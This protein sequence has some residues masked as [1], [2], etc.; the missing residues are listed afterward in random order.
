M[1]RG[2]GLHRSNRPC[3]VESDRAA[4]LHICVGVENVDHDTT[5][6]HSRTFPLRLDHDLL[7]YYSNKLCRPVRMFPRFESRSSSSI[8]KRQTTW[9]FC[10]CSV[11]QLKATF[12]LARLYSETAVIF[13]K[14][15]EQNRYLARTTWISALSSTGSNRKNTWAQVKWNESV[16][17]PKREQ[18]IDGGSW[19]CAKERNKRRTMDMYIRANKTRWNTHTP[20]YRR[21]AQLESIYT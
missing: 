12:A 5:K 7:P 16:W 10:R 20:M 14:H 3:N 15:I 9:R 8:Q 11:S 4:L 21:S 19:S 17:E 1:L 18:R 2:H 6:I 13:R